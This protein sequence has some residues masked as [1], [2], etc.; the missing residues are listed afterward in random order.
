MRGVIY[1]R[2]SCDKQTEQSIEGQIRECK[3]YARQHDILIVGEYIDRAISG[4]SDN[5]E[6][7]QRMIGDSSKKLFDA[8]ITYKTDR[9][10]RNRYDSAWYKRI[11]RNNG[12]KLHYAKEAIPNGPEGIILESLLEGMAEYYSAELSQKVNRGMRETALKRKITGKA[13]YGYKADKDKNYIIDESAAT[14]VQT[15]FNMYENG[16]GPKDICAHL[17][18]L[19]AKT[20]YNKPF[21]LSS[22]N[23]ILNNERYTGV[24]KYAEIRIEDG[25]PAIITKEQF[26]RV[27]KIL[28]SKKQ[29]PGRGRKTEYYLSGK[30]Y[31]GEC[32]SGMRGEYGTSRSG[33][34]YY[35]YTCVNRKEQKACSKKNVPKEWLETLVVA[36]TERLI[37]TEE[38]I[39]VIAK[40]CAAL[41]QKER[42]DNSEVKMLK[43]RLEDTQKAI[44]NMMTAIEQGIITPKTK[45]RLI[46]LEQDEAKI[47]HE[48]KNASVEVPHL[49]ETHIKYMLSQFLRNEQTSDE[50]FTKQ[51][52]ECFIHSVHLFEDRLY[53]VYNLT[54]GNDMKKTESDFAQLREIYGSAFH[55]I[56]S[57][58]LH[59][60]PHV[61]NAVLHACVSP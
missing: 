28:A 31:C 42:T 4:T 60:I 29:A 1:A 21:N 51:I 27:Q 3:E 12:V 14:I 43:K 5:R 22:I 10:A 37:L 35:Y 58:H 40:Q 44:E 56:G 13:P 53:I 19:G 30:L 20:G 6:E 38:Q 55:E 18:S 17:N 46:Q 2:Y 49:T 59:Y 16:T 57:L 39:D 25:M 41:H 23:A 34:K 47:K 8:V 50:N 61:R 45:E 9:I 36:E 7:F 11:L 33:A 48:I 26:C 24:Y 32:G 15:I 54:E 52:I